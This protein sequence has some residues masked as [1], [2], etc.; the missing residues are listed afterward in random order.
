MGLGTN[1]F[2]RLDVARIM[3]QK[4]LQESAENLGRTHTRT[5]HLSEKL[6]KIIIKMMKYSTSN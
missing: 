6:D 5:I 4:Q 1:Y 3:I 2:Y